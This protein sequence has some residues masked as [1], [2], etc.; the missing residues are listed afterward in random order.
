MIFS[1]LWLASHPWLLPYHHRRQQSEE[2]E[3]NRRRAYTNK[4]NNKL[5]LFSFLPSRRK[6]PSLPPP[7]LDDMNLCSFLQDSC[8]SDL[9]PKIL[10]FCTPQTVAA[11][12]RVNWTWYRLIM[13][14]A[15]WRVLCEELY[16]WSDGDALPSISWREYYQ[17]NPCVPIDYP[18]LSA[19]LATCET[20]AL[21][22]GTLQQ[23]KS[24]RILL[25]PGTHVLRE[26]ITIQAK[27]GVDI[28]IE[29]CKATNFTP[30]YA[31]Q[32]DQQDVSTKKC[33]KKR[34]LA[35]KLRSSMNCRSV[36]DSQD[37][38]VADNY[39]Y[40]EQNVGV[41]P[42]STTKPVNDSVATLVLKTNRPNEPL[43]RVKQGNLHLSNIYL[44]HNCLGMDIWNGNACIQIQPPKNSTNNDIP[45]THLVRPQV[46][47]DSV[48]VVS[49]SGR[50]IVNIDGGFSSIQNCHVHDCAATGIYVGGPG[51][52][53]II[54]KTDVL[55]NGNGNVRARG[56]RQVVGR[57]HSGVYLEQGKA[58]I[59]DCN[60]SRNSLTGISAVSLH[61]T[62]L[63]LES[64]DL[65][66]NGM[67]QLEMPR[68][69]TSRDLERN[70]R[71]AAIGLLRS[72][73][74]LVAASVHEEEQPPEQAAV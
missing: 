40:L 66:A 39:S 47:M 21:E 31:S 41:E 10:A 37:V 9:L 16:K 30:V 3:L 57:G 69:G 26:A 63:D 5:T 25:R 1:L 68:G 35:R 7:T 45:T 13:D 15:T 73:S 11:L 22:D 56:T 60:I 18:T 74:G 33:L 70:N 34:R 38:V 12:S 19:A 59:R 6:P 29:T 49:H 54:T 8:P 23:S 48:D 62:L 14:D 17:A 24:I 51:T 46:W 71:L 28:A 53:A 67:A 32:Y 44:L 64:S 61:N 50:G 20:R 42:V 2:E 27:E 65:V 58:I 55:K 43:V 72:R 4:Q 52:Q 36:Q